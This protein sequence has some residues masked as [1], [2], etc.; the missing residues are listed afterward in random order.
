M[1]VTF[2]TKIIGHISDHE[3]AN[4]LFDRASKIEQNIMRQGE[5]FTDL[6]GNTYRHYYYSYEPIELVSSNSDVAALI[7]AHNA[8]SQIKRTF[9]KYKYSKEEIEQLKKILFVV[10]D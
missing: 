6:E 8:L 7:D 2:T 3:L 1:E 4:V 10:K 5:F 9:E